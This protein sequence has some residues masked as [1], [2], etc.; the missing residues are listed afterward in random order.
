MYVGFPMGSHSMGLPPD[1]RSIS[2]VSFA[3]MPPLPSFTA[4]R[5]AMRSAL[6]AMI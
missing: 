6:V 2:A 3:L 5:K 1:D 4:S